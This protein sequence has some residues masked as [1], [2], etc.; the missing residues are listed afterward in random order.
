[1]FFTGLIAWTLRANKSA[2]AE[3][4][5]QI[6]DS[7]ISRSIAAYP[8]YRNKDGLETYNFWRTNPSGH[9]PN[10]I[11]F[12][13]FRKFRIPDDIDD[14]SIIYLSSDHPIEEVE[15]LKERMIQHANLSKLKIKNTFKKYRDLKAY[16]TWFGK[17]MPIDFDVCV[18]TN[19]LNFIYK[20]KLP[21]NEYDSAS[22]KFIQSVLLADEHIKKPF[23]VAR[24]YRKTSVILY[25]GLKY[26]INKVLLFGV[27]EE[28]SEDGSSSCSHNSVVATAVRELKKY[29]GSD[30]YI[31]T[32]ICLCAYTTHGHCGVLKDDY[33]QNDPTLEILS[34]M[35][36]AHAEAGADMVAP[37][38]MYSSCWR[39]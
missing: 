16:S 26:G 12:S 36:L 4:E 13:K 32:D 2:L 22:I 19:T 27:G 14:T 6:A 15:T 25:H 9:F 37:S 35:A 21:L 34:K 17:K 11:F 31:I 33:V 29:F 8:A 24:H 1:M 7:I 10:G 23:Y 30:L 28:K 39:N 38:D 5:K 20:Y 18:L 3:Q